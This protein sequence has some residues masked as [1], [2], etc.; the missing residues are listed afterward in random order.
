[1]NPMNQI[2][3]SRLDRIDA[4]LS[5]LIDSI[6]SYNPSIAAAQDLL[7]A[8]DALN[9]GVKQLVT[10]QRNHSRITS[11]RAEI[12]T[13]NAAITAKLTSLATLRSDILS[14]KITPVAD[15]ARQVSCGELLD[16]AQRIS[17]YTIPP[18]YPVSAQ[19]PP[20]T[21][22]GEAAAEAAKGEVNG[23]GAEQVGQAENR[24]EAE[25]QAQAQAPVMPNGGSFV[26]WPS[27]EVI[28][29]GAL[30]QIQVLLEQGIDPTT[31]GVEGGQKMEEVI[32][33]DRKE[34]QRKDDA[35]SHEQPTRSQQDSTMVVEVPREEKPK[36]FGGLD[37]YD[38]DEE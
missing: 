21:T 3:Q 32:E 8:D 9:Q 16:Y 10:H 20:E 27:E 7:A 28:R 22:A 23:A 11:L 12:D 25:A 4:S 24:N 34:E 6:A 19:Q 30:G 17:R 13:S 14:R 5:A 1:M 18:P 26:P 2:M 37:L 15:D 33:D 36:V 38:P 31:I 29:Q 35:A